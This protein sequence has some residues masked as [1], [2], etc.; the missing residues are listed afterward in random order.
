MAMIGSPRN[1]GV[2]AVGGAHP[3]H[4]L[5]EFLNRQLQRSATATC[6]RCRSNLD[7]EPYDS[8]DPPLFEAEAAYLERHGLLLPGERKQ[9]SAADFKPGAVELEAA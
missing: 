8:A 4:R 1:W 5:C 2:A 7:C 3:R 9:L 6:G